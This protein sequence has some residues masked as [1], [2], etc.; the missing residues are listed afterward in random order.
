[1]VW[2][3]EAI[4]KQREGNVLVTA[5]KQLC[6]EN[7]QQLRGRSRWF[8]FFIFSLRKCLLLQQLSNFHFTALCVRVLERFMQ[9]GRNKWKNWPV[10]PWSPWPFHPGLQLRENNP[11]Q[12]MQK[13]SLQ[14][15]LQMLKRDICFWLCLM[16][17]TRWVALTSLLSKQLSISRSLT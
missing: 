11:L 15:F 7:T 17:G 10:P 1:M 14:F 2:K 12:I 6:L 13:I 4:S 9:Y 8:L 3:A 16:P 5:Q